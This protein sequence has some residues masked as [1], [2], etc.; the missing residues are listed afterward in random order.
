MKHHF[1]ISM[2]FTSYACIVAFHAPQSTSVVAF[3]HVS[4]SIEH[5]VN[6]VHGEIHL[7]S[8]LACGWCGREKMQDRSVNAGEECL[9]EVNAW[10]D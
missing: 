9:S 6:S 2:N 5:G 8:C 7:S 4:S 10:L 3:V 1:C